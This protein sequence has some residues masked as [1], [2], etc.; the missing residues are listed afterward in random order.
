M[1]DE[2]L[3]DRSGGSDPDVARLET[4]LARYRSP[5]SQ[6]PVARRRPHPARWFAAAGLAAA[7]ALFAIL[8]LPARRSDQ[9]SLAGPRGT[10]RVAVGQTVRTGPGSRARLSSRAVGMVDV[11]E[12]TVLRVEEAREGR[13]VLEL[14]VGTIHAKTT[15]PPGVFVVDTP[16]ARAMDLGCEY[17]LSVE[18]AGEGRL[19]VDSG[20]VGLTRYGRQSLVP[21]RASASF[22]REGNLMPPVFD[23]APAG[24]LDAVREFSLGEPAA[25]RDAALAAILELARRRDALTLLNLFPIASPEERLRVYDRLNA[26]VP[27]PAAV[28]REAVENWRIGTTDAW[29]RPV[30]EASGVRAIKKGKK[31]ISLPR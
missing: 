28:T 20:W 2:Y 8:T 27:A 31:P 18:P 14:A 9:W 16:R 15:S 10:E 19:H 11:A 23:D 21:E 26:L 3:W 1:S 4:L 6:A 22:D 29:W 13:S 7:A 12:N 5:G 30:F 25:T 24:F 17:T